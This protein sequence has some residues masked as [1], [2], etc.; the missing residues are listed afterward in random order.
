MFYL[1][2]VISWVEKFQE[3]TRVLTS[4]RLIGLIATWLFVACAPVA[5][6]SSIL[7]PEHVTIN[8]QVMAAKFSGKVVPATPNKWKAS[9]YYERCAGTSAVCI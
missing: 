7:A 9:P 3:R 6:P 2:P 5:P 8:L 1:L 4:K